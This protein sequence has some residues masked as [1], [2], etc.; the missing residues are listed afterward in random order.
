MAC[1]IPNSQIKGIAK[2]LSLNP[3]EVNAVF[4]IVNDIIGNGTDSVNLFESDSDMDNFIKSFIS[5]SKNFDNDNLKQ[6]LSAKVKEDGGNPILTISSVMENEFRNMSSNSKLK[7]DYLSRFS[8]DEIVDDNINDFINSI[9]GKDEVE[10][11]DILEKIASLN[12]EYINNGIYS[13]IIS[14]YKTLGLNVK[15]KFSDRYSDL[16]L[17]ASN[18]R[19]YFDP[20]TNTIVINKDKSWSAGRKNGMSFSQ[21]SQT[22]FHEITHAI[23][24]KILHSK[25][26]YAK[27]EELIEKIKMEAQKANLSI[28]EYGFK[29][30]DELLAELMNGNFMNHLMKIKMDKM[31]A[32]NLNYAESKVEQVKQ[33]FIDKILSMIKEFFE[34]LF[35]SR[36]SAQ[37]EPY[38]AFDA[39]KE[40]LYEIINQSNGVFINDSNE[41]I[42]SQ[43]DSPNTIEFSGKNYIISMSDV[44]DNSVRSVLEN[45]KIL[46]K[47]GKVVYESPQMKS[48]K[49]KILSSWFEKRNSAF[50]VEYNGTKYSVVLNDPKP[51]IMSMA[52]GKEVYEDENDGNR[53]KIIELAREKDWERFL[54]PEEKEEEVD[55]SPIQY[56]E[57]QINA[58]NKCVDWLNK[59]TKPAE[60][61]TFIGKAGTGKTTCAKKII[62]D[63]KKANP[64]SSIVMGALSWQATEVLKRS[65]GKRK[66]NFL[67]I[68]SMFKFTERVE[69]DEITFSRD[70]DF[71][72]E[73]EKTEK[74]PPVWF[75]DLIVIDE[76]SMVSRQQL[77]MIE[78]DII[79]ASKRFKRPC[80]KILFLGDDGQLNPVGENAISQTFSKYGEENHSRL[81][82]RMRQGEDNPI[83]QYADQYW[84]NSHIKNPES[85]SIMSATE[86]NVNSKGGIVTITKMSDQADA[87]Y[88]LFK[89]ANEVEGEQFLV[90]AIVWRNHQV[91]FVNRNIHK[92]LYPDS[93]RQFEVGEFAKFYGNFDT[94]DDYKIRNS[95]ELRIKECSEDKVE[96]VEGL[97]IK[98]TKLK[99]IQEYT[100]YNGEE[101]VRTITVKAVDADTVSEIK[102]RKRQIWNDYNGVFLTR[103]LK[104]ERYN[105]YHSFDMFVEVRNNYAVTSHKAQGSTYDV[106][107]VYED[108]MN[109]NNNKDGSPNFFERSRCIYTAATRAKNLT[110]VI[111]K[112]ADKTDKDIYKLNDEINDV[113][114]GKIKTPTELSKGSNQAPK[115]QTEE[116]NPYG[117]EYEPDGTIDIFAGD[118]K[119]TI[120]SNFAERP[121]YPGTEIVKG[122]FKTVEGAFQAQK[123]AYNTKYKTP[124][125]GEAGEI[126]EKLLNADGLTARNIGRSIQGLDVANWNKVSSNIMKGLIYD[127]FKWNEEAK[128]ALLSTGDAILT[129]KKGTGKWKTEFPKLLM[130]VR[131]KLRN[132]QDPQ[133]PSN[134]QPPTKPVKTQ[135]T[136][137]QTEIE[138][139][140]QFDEM[141]NVL[142]NR[143]M[144][145]GGITITNGSNEL[146]SI[147]KDWQKENPNGIVAFRIWE[148]GKSPFTTDAI[149]NN[150]IGN[151]FSVSQRGAET[152]EMFGKWLF[153]L[154]YATDDV[155][156][157][158]LNI[159]T[160]EQS[161]KLRMTI[162][163]KISNVAKYYANSKE[164]RVLYYTTTTNK[165]GTERPSHASVIE[166]FIE[167]FI[168]HHP[169]WKN[170]NKEAMKDYTMYSGGAIGGDEMWDEIGRKNGLVNAKHYMWFNGKNVEPAKSQKVRATA[171]PEDAMHTAQDEMRKIFKGI[172]F[173]IDSK[174]SGK[175]FRSRLWVRDYWQAQ[176]ADAIYAVVTAHTNH[177]VIGGTNYAVQTGISMNKPV[178]IFDASTNK[179]YLYK[180]GTG[181][182]E[183]ATPVLE[184][185]FAGIGSRDFSKSHQGGKKYNE[186]YDKRARLAIEQVYKNT[187]NGGKRSQMVEDI[188]KE[189]E[190][191]EQLVKE[192]EEAVKNALK[193]TFKNN[194][195]D[196]SIGI[197]KLREKGL[198]NDLQKIA[199]CNGT[200]TEVELIDNSKDYGHFP[201]QPDGVIR[202]LRIQGKSNVMS[203][204]VDHVVRDKDKGTIKFYGMATLKGNNRVNEVNTSLLKEFTS[205]AKESSVDANKKDVYKRDEDA[206]RV[207]GERMKDSESY[208]ANLFKEKLFS[209]RNEYLNSQNAELKKTETDESGNKFYVHNSIEMRDI[210]NNINNVN[211]AIVLNWK[212][213]L[214]IFKEI[215]EEI[216]NKAKNIMDIQVDPFIGPDGLVDN[217]SDFETKAYGLLNATKEEFDKATANMPFDQKSMFKTYWSE[218]Q[219]VTDNDDKWGYGVIEEILEE[220]A[221]YLNDIVDYFDV[222]SRNAMP[223]ILQENAVK[224]NY[225]GVL[226]QDNLGMVENLDN[227][228]ADSVNDDGTTNQ[229]DNAHT[230]EESAREE[231][232]YEK[233]TRS[234]HDT[235]TKEVYKL[236][237][238]L[239]EYTNGS[240]SSDSL[241][242]PKYID[243]MKAYTTLQTKLNG[244]YSD[245]EMIERIKE[246]SEVRES[247]KTLYDRITDGTSSGHKIKTQL[248]NAFCSQKKNFFINKKS[249]VQVKKKGDYV[250]D[251][252]G[253]HWDPNAE[254]TETVYVTK[255][256]QVNDSNSEDIMVSNALYNISGGL[257]LANARSIYNANGNAN[258]ANIANL[259]ERLEKMMSDPTYTNG[260][261]SAINNSQ[262]SSD[263]FNGDGARIIRFVEVCL[264]SLGIEYD[265]GYLANKIKRPINPRFDTSKTQNLDKIL[266]VLK[267]VLSESNHSLYIKEKDSNIFNIEIDKMKE[268]LEKIAV[269]IGDIDDGGVESTTRSNGK[270]MMSYQQP[271]YES[272]LFDKLRNSVT[273]NAGADKSG[274]PL[275]KNDFI[276][277]EFGRFNWFKKDGVYANCWL[278]DFLDK[279]SKFSPKDFQHMVLLSADDISYDEF[280][281]SKYASVLMNQYFAGRYDNNGNSKQNEF[282]YFAVPVLA[283]APSCEFVRARRR[284]T[285]NRR[286][287]S[288]EDRR[289]A[290]ESYIN[291]NIDKLK[292]DTLDG[293]KQW[294]ETDTRPKGSEFRTIDAEITCYYEMAQ[295][296]SQEMGRIAMVMERAKNRNKAVD[297]YNAEK[298]K[299]KKENRDLPI[300]SICGMD[301]WTESI[302]NWDIPQPTFD[303]KL[304][305]VKVDFSN[306]KKLPRG[307][308]FCFFP[309]LNKKRF[310]E[311][312]DM[313]FIEYIGKTYDKIDNN[314]LNDKSVL[315]KAMECIM[316][317]Q[318][319]S[320]VNAMKQWMSD[321]TI[322]KEDNNFGDNSP[323][324]FEKKGKNLT[325]DS[326][327]ALKDY[328]LQSSLANIMIQELTI[329][330]PAYYKNAN[331]FQK[332]NK[333]IYSPSK[334]LDIHAEYG[335]EFERTLT[336][337][338][339]ENPT[340]MNVNNVYDKKGNLLT[341]GIKDIMKFAVG[342]GDIRSE[343]AEQVIKSVEKA[344][345][346]VNLADAQALCTPKAFRAVMSMSGQL[347]DEMEGVLNRMIEDKYESNEQ[348]RK[349]VST[350]LMVEKPFTYTQ[351]TVDSGTEFGPIRVGNQHKTSVFPMLWATS[352]CRKYANDVET[353]KDTPNGIGANG[354]KLIKLVEF[355]DKY[356]ID[357]VQF[358]SAVK[359]GKRGCINV[360]GINADNLI[361]HLEK[362][363]GFD[364]LVDGSGK[365]TC[366][367][368]MLTII[369]YEDYG[370][371]ASTPEHLIDIDQLVGSQIRRLNM[372]D[373]DENTIF[374]VKVNGE[375]VGF[376]KQQ[377]I[378]HYNAVITENILEEFRKID[379]IFSNVEEIER[380]LINE[381]RGNAQYTPEMIKAARLTTL[382]NGEKVFDLVSD[383]VVS[384]KIESLLNSI[385]RSR[386]TK[387]KIKGGA[388]IQVSCFGME[389][390]EVKMSSDGKKVEYMECM[391]PCYSKDLID[392]LMDE[393]GFINFNRINDEDLFDDETREAILT[394]IGYRVPTEDKYSMAPLRVVGFLPPSNGSVIMLPAEITTLSGSDF[395][396]DKMYLMLH[397]FNKSVSIKWSN[398]DKIRSTQRA[399]FIHYV[400]EEFIKNGYISDSVKDILTYTDEQ[401]EH[402]ILEEVDEKRRNKEELEGKLKSKYNRIFRKIAELI[403]DNKNEK[404]FKNVYRRFTTG[405]DAIKFVS[406]VKVAKYKSDK[407]T[408]YD[409]KLSCGDEAKKNTKASRNNRMLDLMY[410]SLTNENTAS[411]F[412]MPGS[413]DI[414]KKSARII[415]IYEKVKPTDIQKFLEDKKLIEEGKFNVNDYYDN[416]KS[417]DRE[418]L[419]DILTSYADDINPISPV[420]QVY[421]HSQNANGGKLIGVYA[422][423]NCGHALMQYTHLAISDDNKFVLNGN[424]IKALNNNKHYISKNCA[425]FLAASVDNVKDPVLSWLN[426]N[427]YTADTAMLLT[428]LGYDVDTIAVLMNQPI[429]K[430]VTELFKKGVS[431]DKKD[432]F[433]K[434]CKELFND[435]TINEKVLVDLHRLNM[436]DGEIFEF[437]ANVLAKELMKDNNTI[438]EE[439][440]NSS[441]EVPSVQRRVAGLLYHLIGVAQDLS[442]LTQIVKVDTQNGGLKSSVSEN[443]AKIRKGEEFINKLNNGETTLS[444]LYVEGGVPKND[445]IAYY[446]NDNEL[447][448]FHKKDEKGNMTTTESYNDLRRKIYDSVSPMIS[449]FG[450]CGVQS[451]NR[452]F[453]KL[454]PQYNEVIQNVFNKFTKMKGDSLSSAEIKSIYK[455]LVVYWMSGIESFG[456]DSNIGDRNLNIHDKRKIFIDSFPDRF[457]EYL[458]ESEDMKNIDFLKALKIEEVKRTWYDKDLKKQERTIKTLVLPNVGSLP[459]QIK[460]K[461]SWEWEKMFYSKDV[462]QHDCAVKLLI[463]SY[464]RNGLGFGPNS[465]G[466]LAPLMRTELPGYR[467]R[468]RSLLTINDDSVFDLFI[469]QYVRNHPNSSFV[470]KIGKNE[471]REIINDFAELNNISETQY[472]YVSHFDKNGN[473]VKE[474]DINDNN[475]EGMTSTF[476]VKSTPNVFKVDP[477]ILNEGKDLDDKFAYININNEIFKQTMLNGEYVYVKMSKLGF[478]HGSDNTEFPEYSVTPITRSIFEN[479]NISSNQES[480]NIDES[481]VAGLVKNKVDDDGRI[482][483]EK[484]EIEEMFTSIILNNSN[485]EFDN[486][487][488]NLYKS[489]LEKE[490]RKAYESASNRVYRGC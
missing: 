70:K 112:Q 31:V 454:F 452:Y 290:I 287:I 313:T 118:N 393:E 413:F 286:D 114:S 325:K 280:N 48:T 219:L 213:P 1:S 216:A 390:L 453:K 159:K 475:R 323:I 40:F 236:L 105:R 339:I 217:N 227:S 289:I 173:D 242:N 235:L 398:D 409:N 310:G 359:V 415:E 337:S 243:S 360:N 74:Y 152:V 135:A 423:H 355:M 439:Y 367:K 77:K 162:L 472:G 151:P 279:D 144:N 373:I 11:S 169:E 37:N 2:R 273:Y 20:K 28:D 237:S 489:V 239:P 254:R 425:G 357:L 266:N 349:D 246:L 104:E 482:D 376:T 480:L 403:M 352:L 248:F 21:V 430:K 45:A 128:K 487:D 86:D 300:E 251:D 427:G 64:N 27:G 175:R 26:N 91:D 426:Q 177:G 405:K 316:E 434:A 476:T 210:Q 379:K 180:K 43:E 260:Y 317:T 67:S 225:D 16:S 388:C 113:K 261:K 270:Q 205:M 119:N 399:K 54:A 451:T 396:V 136:K 89:R 315:G 468:F 61:Y 164:P 229:Q 303:K 281:D 15:I 212:S 194:N 312:K 88:K 80:A 447:G 206:S 123:L 176:R 488:L 336:I 154:A 68:A 222:V 231:F 441:N 435:K 129:H 394:M 358:E 462:L 56:T 297:L 214:T 322:N 404:T 294:I 340:S 256:Y 34:N 253:R 459:D 160:K 351:T 408:D 329:T 363:T 417:L 342:R 490:L 418:T 200:N 42:I 158:N 341:Y 168:E 483:N 464:Y 35:N 167:K 353:G 344:Y 7:S 122:D 25:D 161:D 139:E 30:P 85:T 274:K 14:A 416:L 362:A 33:G 484:D 220:R 383:P 133:P 190:R 24:H 79:Y 150:I 10:A 375:T 249:P 36:K 252:E 47:D 110:V 288:V 382:P 463:Y 53:S 397:E 311:K 32:D 401:G 17:T 374:D 265:K 443:I 345:K 424:L 258:M 385:I 295:V 143:K 392:V 486:S 73:V 406:T 13:N 386:I 432:L 131:E 179:W 271:S 63:Y 218:N 268:Q 465:F 58:I 305:A 195:G 201:E 44:K 324:R 456:T 204:S 470:N 157:E 384:T 148:D 165:D 182:V 202:Y 320:F 233:G 65:V 223:Q 234:I 120:L 364:H 198:S 304:N 264:N 83:L 407:N 98:Y 230:R 479:N 338:D 440:R 455:D 149:D 78:E 155:T 277:K 12:D 19:A 132:E 250:V 402:N 163:N 395:D 389:G 84:E 308:Q 449:A 90:K 9:V 327:N 18:Q 100:T 99:V 115:V 306:M 66:A 263:F 348:R 124:Y 370:I 354:K 477:N 450:Y 262:T 298:E 448:D 193:T 240:Q 41:N 49:N 461:Y 466:H 245:V 346:K 309:A 184:K 278:R 95:D 108:D 134:P 473:F 125:H 299:A 469:E 142:N 172:D 189:I 433:I 330:D 365:P 107:F 485:E 52:S 117:I 101:K 428:R 96:N 199:E 232:T 121:L 97:D 356:D 191:N 283:D 62:S 93:T 410:S 321:G 474:N 446:I 350:S 126:R 209:Y 72:T 343:D 444:T 51:M 478:S 380:L 188:F 366:Y 293:L 76:C 82:T 372:A 369:P 442:T 257:M 421:F 296:V 211:N 59:E 208:V 275:M 197:E 445:N 94:N 46:N 285:I 431:G 381:M 420:T 106:A 371:Q 467:E 429:F 272:K 438:L 170:V 145:N 50:S 71:Y 481:Y 185:N 38:T 314:V 186:E 196:V 224:F 4:D 215:R 87:V 147:Y 3:E 69:N 127:S 226:T 471:V 103:E 400:K 92:M 377:F 192:A 156:G 460:A 422:N 238:S 307:L 284:T 187:A 5:F 332:R 378:N 412:L 458:N 301:G 166:Y 22:I 109:L 138:Y 140:K 171:V 391:L 334:K 8:N 81:V 183:E 414:Q 241:G 153:G 181:F 111:N 207:I 174:D 247:Y 437:K 228:D 178:H 203:I 267:N 457:V 146:K 333:Q 55:K 259:R 244:I 318:E 116:K 130:E 302:E 326:V 75:A 411:K 347:T 291:R 141:M 23:T 368:D 255:C 319:E 137:S 221:G 29:N 6:F 57:E 39:T 331:D 292:K 328:F 387:Q 102:K 269:V 419:D 335:K 282:A 60:F 436:K 361:A 276:D